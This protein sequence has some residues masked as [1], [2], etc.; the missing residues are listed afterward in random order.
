MF[1]AERSVIEPDLLEKGRVLII[2][3]DDESI[4]TLAQFLENEAYKFVVAKTDEE[5]LSLYQSFN[6]EL[7][8]IGIVAGSIDGYKIAEKL[9]EIST[10]NFLPII[11]ITDLESE[12]VMKNC[13]SY[14]G[15]DV[16]NKP[17]NED[18]LKTRIK[19]YIRLARLE[20]ENKTQQ[21]EIESHNKKLKSSYDVAID[22]FHK[23]IHSDVLDAPG[24]KY[25]ISPIS[26]FNGDLY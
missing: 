17:C 14:S 13:L 1:A 5:A 15:T 10:Q 18:I 21:I 9:T 2:D 16:L 8:I 19:T 3:T 22:V 4:D 12:E 7:V 25:S 26:I 6:P 24:I 23:V 20:Q 11:F